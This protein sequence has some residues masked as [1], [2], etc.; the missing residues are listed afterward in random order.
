M[1]KN[2]EFQIN[3]HFTVRLAQKEDLPH[4]VAIYNTTVSSR[5]VTADTEPVTVESKEAWFEA[6]A[7]TQRP[8]WVVL[9]PDEEVVAW[10]SFK[11]F[12]GRPAYRGTAEISIY[13]APSSR[14][15]GLGNLLLQFA[16]DQAP[17]WEVDTLLAFIFSHNHPSQILFKKFGFHPW[18]LLPEVA[19]MD[20]RRYSLSILGRKV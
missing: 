9:N 15:Q 10:V 19:V 11:S 8:L 6:H 2:S 13:I 12:Y 14:K 7:S 1:Q 18:G 17:A 4:I 3:Q 5:L 20:G 16:L